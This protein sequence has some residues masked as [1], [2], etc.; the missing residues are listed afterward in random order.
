MAVCCFA[1]ASGLV[2]GTAHAF[3]AEA[4]N[5]N[6]LLIVA[7]DLGYSDLGCYGG[8]IETPHLDQLANEGVRLTQFHTMARCC[9]SRACLLTGQYPHRVGLGHM[10]QDIGQ[11]GYRGRVDPHAPTIADLLQ[12][13]GFRTF[14]SGKWH[15]GTPDPTRHGFEQFYGTLVSAKTFW[16]REHYLQIPQSKLPDDLGGEPFYGTDALTD[17]AIH[18]LSEARQTPDQPWFLYLAY[19]APHFPLQARNEEI[20]KYADRYHVG[21]DVIRQERLRRMKTL[22][23]IPAEARLSE[24]SPYWNYGETETGTNP[25]WETLPEARR[26][27]LARRMAIYAAMVDRMDAGIGRLTE[28]L[29]SQDELDNTL[30]IFLSDNG[31]CAEWDPRGFDGKSS[32]HNVLHTAQGLDTMGGPETFHSVGSAWANASNTPFR[33]YKHFCHQGGVLSPCIVR[34]PSAM[35]GR[36]SG[37]TAAPG[38]FHRKP[39]HLIDVLPT[40]L[41]AANA[42]YPSSFRGGATQPP[43][44]ISLVKQFGGDAPEPRAIFMEHEGNRG[45]RRGRWKLVALRDEPWELY[46][47]VEDPIESHDLAEQRPAVVQRLASLWSRW[48]AENHVT[49]LPD[50]YHVDYLKPR[51]QP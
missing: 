9:P 5:P 22:G 51:A 50:D 37:I 33:L 17:R 10:T 25:S 26:M 28:D 7:D 40:I 13:Q 34:W 12:R 39:A 15:L 21:W 2:H 24:R 32:N 8:E 47:L 14:L 6:V 20:A 23:V 27:D 31:A 45:L 30:I 18:F 36:P 35:R 1:W 49:P 4:S 42:S 11:P 43:V 16:R 46:D 44:G 38:G 3:G 29:K 19:N 48:A 41:H